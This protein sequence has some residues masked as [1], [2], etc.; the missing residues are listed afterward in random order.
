MKGKLAGAL[1]GIKINVRDKEISRIGETEFFK[2]GT[3]AMG[4]QIPEEFVVLMSG[5]TG[6]IHIEALV[7]NLNSKTDRIYEMAALVPDDTQWEILVDYAQR[8]GLVSKQRLLWVWREA[9]RLGIPT[10]IR[11]MK[12]IAFGAPPTKDK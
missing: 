10:D 12:D 2:L 5:A 8:S 1:A 9:R 11:G 7:Q 3:I 6:K 4:K